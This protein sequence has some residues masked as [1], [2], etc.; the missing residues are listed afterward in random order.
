[1]TAVTET[2]GA[3]DATIATEGACRFR[4]AAAGRRPPGPRTAPPTC[5]CCPGSSASSASRSR[6]SSPRCILSFTD[7]DILS[8]ARLDRPR[9]LSSQLFTRPPL[10]QGD[11]GDAHLCRLVGAAD[12]DLLA[13][14]RRHPQSRARRPRDLPVALLRAL[15]DR[16]ERRHRPLVARGLRNPRRVQRVPGAVRHPRQGLDRAIRSTRSTP[17]SACTSGRSAHRW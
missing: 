17:S 16:R 1:M 15:A 2:A 8:A 13:D 3:P 9:Q 11:L 10:H 6:R 14:H 7:Y 12:P 4:R 5:S